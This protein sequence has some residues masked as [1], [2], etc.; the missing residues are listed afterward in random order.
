MR[1]TG[2][3]PGIST[4]REEIVAAAAAAFASSGYDGTSLRQIAADA[5][6]DPAMVRRFFGGKE[7]LFSAVVTSV[8]QP[9]QAVAMLLDGPRGKIGGRLAEYVVGLLGEV[10]RPGPVLGLMRSAASSEHAA[11]LVRQFLANEMLGR[12][13]QK[14]GVDHPQLRAALTA[15]QL[16]GLAITRYVVRAEALVSTE[17]NDLIAWVAPTLQRYLTGRIP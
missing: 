17:T 15:S 1:R 8:F 16:V 13:T 3:R 6:L 14:L 5:G 7:Q 9:E 10:E 12:L 4:T 2:R 11:A